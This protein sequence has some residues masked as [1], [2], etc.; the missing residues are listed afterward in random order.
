M[1]NLL[2]IIGICL[3]IV[4]VYFDRKNYEEIINE[5]VNKFDDANGMEEL[6]LRIGN[7]EN[8]LYKAEANYIEDFNDIKVEIEEDVDFSS[9]MDYVSSQSNEKEQEISSVYQDAFKVI[10]LYNKG[11]YTLEEA[12]RILNMKKGEVLLLKNMYK[13]YQQ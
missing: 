9:V 8:L 7:I 3:I 2:I 1:F 11:D 5:D 10:A 12:C 4:G 6:L 13:K